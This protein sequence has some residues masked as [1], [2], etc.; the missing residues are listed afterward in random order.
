MEVFDGLRQHRFPLL[1]AAMSGVGMHVL[2]SNFLPKNITQF[3]SPKA[4]GNP[5]RIFFRQS[6]RSPPQTRFA[7]KKVGENHSIHH[8]HGRPSSIAS[9]IS[10]AVMKRFIPARIFSVS[11]IARLILS[12]AIATRSGSDCP[13]TRANSAMIS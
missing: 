5:Y 4:A 2:K 13:E 9:S 10:L 3:V 8:N 7:R 12:R 1:D 11:L 6:D